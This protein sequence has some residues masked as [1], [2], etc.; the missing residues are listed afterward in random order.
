MIN[1]KTAWQKLSVI[2]SLKEVSMSS[3]EL[4]DL[5][6]P[7]FIVK[8]KG[9]YG[10]SE[11]SAEF[12]TLRAKLRNIGNE[13]IKLKAKLYN[14]ERSFKS[15]T[16]R[17]LF[18]KDAE[19]R[20]TKQKFN[21]LEAQEKTLRTQFLNQLQSTT[22][23]GNYAMV[24]KEPVAI[25]YKGRELLSTLG[26]RISRV[27]REDLKSFLSELQQLNTHFYNCSNKGGGILKILSPKYG[28][29]DEIHLRFTSV[30]LACR[31]GQIND[32]VE[33]FNRAS[34]SITQTLKGTKPV[35]LTLAEALT[36]MAKDSDELNELLEKVPKLIS[37]PWGGVSVVDDQVRAAGIILSCHGNIITLANTARIIADSYC[38]GNYSAAAFLTSIKPTEMGDSGFASDELPSKIDS[39]MGEVIFKFQEFVKYLSQ[40]SYDETEN[41]ITAALLCSSGLPNEAILARY[42]QANSILKKFNG[43]FMQIPSAMLA[44]MPFEIPEA[45]DNMRLA[46]AAISANK[47]SLGGL[48]NLSLGMKLFLNSSVRNLISTARS[49]G[50]LSLISSASRTDL[51]VLGAAG[52]SAAATMSLGMGFL[53]FHEV[54]LHELAVRDFE[55]H[56]VHVHYVYG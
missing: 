14:I 26:Q 36:T 52:I 55:F 47:L 53:A 23:K 41:Y 8:L 25:T 49:D 22:E 29:I 28:N 24:N 44:V 40:F 34:Q 10:R 51:S 16:P 42:S 50:A 31:P 15:K 56:P 12:E 30:G 17:K 32:T 21:D 27:G 37:S 5:V 11:S 4:S 13:K 19:Y 45:L 35:T 46:S 7:G 3:S 54:S 39:N 20:E 18:K 33:L 2:N 48:E 9:V 43:S 38:P 6:S 1:C